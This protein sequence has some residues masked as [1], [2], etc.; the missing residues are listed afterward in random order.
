MADGK[1]A[2]TTVTNGFVRNPRKL[3]AMQPFITCSRRQSKDQVPQTNSETLQ[4]RVVSE[5]AISQA[6]KC[7]QPNHEDFAVVDFTSYSHFA[8]IALTFFSS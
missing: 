1:E 8:R 3:Q 5:F 6:K 2:I 7:R 4:P